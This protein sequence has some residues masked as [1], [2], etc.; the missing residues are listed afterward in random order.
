VFIW[1]VFPVLVCLD[2]EKSGN[3]DFEYIPIYKY[4]YRYEMYFDIDKNVTGSLSKQ[5]CQ[6]NVNFKDSLMAEVETM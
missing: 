3:P 4:E 2:Q 5:Y 6:L 1:Y